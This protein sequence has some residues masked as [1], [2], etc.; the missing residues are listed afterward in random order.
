MDYVALKAELA[1]LAYAGLSDQAAADAL[2]ARTRPLEHVPAEEVSRYILEE[3]RWPLVEDLAS[4]VNATANQR[5][6]AR[7]AV[8][9]VRDA[10]L[11]TV[12]LLR[13]K[14]QAMLDLLVAGGALAAGDKAALNA[15]AENKRTRAEELGWTV[16]IGAG[17][18]ANAR[19]L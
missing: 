16:A 7:A 1:L 9:M 13:P 2:N 17:D 8:S 15:L 3:G 5:R 4:D 19:A 10:R 18:V 11:P 6:A 12:R 14:V